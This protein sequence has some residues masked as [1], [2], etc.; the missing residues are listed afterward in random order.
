MICN[1]ISAFISMN[2][3]D[4]W[5]LKSINFVRKI[6]YF[7]FSRFDVEIIIT[8]K[9]AGKKIE[10]L[11]L[12]CT[13]VFDV[14]IGDIESGAGLQVEIEDVSARQ[15]EGASFKVFD[16]EQGAFSFFCKDFFV[17]LMP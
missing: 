2:P 5:F 4:F 13:G 12:R 17:E 14:S 16:A 15:L 8:K 11:Q 10:D 3:V 7:E 6:D 1:D 9:I